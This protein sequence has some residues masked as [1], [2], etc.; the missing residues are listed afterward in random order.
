MIAVLVPNGARVRF[1]SSVYPDV[2]VWTKRDGRYGPILETGDGRSVI[3]ARQT[4][5]EVQS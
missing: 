3:V 5:V 1:S 4:I 2:R